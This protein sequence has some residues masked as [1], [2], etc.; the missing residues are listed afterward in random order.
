MDDV[1]KSVPSVRAALTVIQEV[2]NLCKRIG[3]KLK[4]L[5]SNKKDVLFQISDELR[6]DCAKDNDLTESIAIERALGIF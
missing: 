3:F 6:R 4:K 2:K 1:L 5:I